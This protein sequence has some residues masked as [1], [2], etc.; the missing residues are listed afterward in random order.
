LKTEYGIAMVIQQKKGN[1]HAVDT[2]NK[3]IDWLHLQ[4][5]ETNKRML[6]KKTKSG[7]EIYLKFLKENAAL[8]EGDILFE[9]EEIIIAVQVIPCDCIVIKPA[10]VFDMASVCYEIGNRHLPLFF[11]NDELLVPFENPLYCLLQAQ[12]F[13]VIKEERKLL[14]PLKTT[15][16]PHGDGQSNT[17]FSRIMKLS[18][19]E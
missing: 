9:N 12:G 6:H 10:N 2:G 13:V 3:N 15:I 17:L 7:T 4:W 16:S 18:N 5:F 8:T 1:I 19:N 14:Q 11:E